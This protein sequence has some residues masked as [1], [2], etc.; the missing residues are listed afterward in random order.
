[1]SQY[2]PKAE[3]FT[4]TLAELVP[5]ARV[6]YDGSREQI[7][8]TIPPIT[9]S[10]AL[11]G[12]QKGSEM[13]HSVV[14]E[15]LNFWSDQFGLKDHIEEVANKRADTK[16]T[17]ALRI[18]SPLENVINAARL[19]LVDREPLLRSLR[20]AEQDIRNLMEKK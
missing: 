12:P 18:L 6:K 11:Y 19:D 16:V 4:E 9:L 8:V 20:K 14:N 3:K 5:A 7:D 10:T 1:M 15:L 2:S 17:A 13:A